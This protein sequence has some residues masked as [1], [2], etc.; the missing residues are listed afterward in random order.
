VPAAVPGNEA[1]ASR[2]DGKFLYVLDTDIHAVTIVDV[3]DAT[4]LKRIPVDKSVN[5]VEVSSDGKDLLC[6]GKTTSR[7]GLALNSP[8]E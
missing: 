3:A 7:I 5:R 6:V 1:L 8:R 2:P 4:V